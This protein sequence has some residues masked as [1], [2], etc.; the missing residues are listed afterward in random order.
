MTSRPLSLLPARRG[1]LVVPPDEL[2]FAGVA[3]LLEASTKKKRGNCQRAKV[4]DV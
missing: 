2:L 4:L 3:A 1:L